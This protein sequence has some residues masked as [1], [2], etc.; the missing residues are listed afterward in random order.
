MFKLVDVT[1]EDVE[2][3]YFELVKTHQELMFLSLLSLPE[4]VIQ[5]L[6][7]ESHILEY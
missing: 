4:E 6:V 7:R 1:A 5:D 2:F 3:M